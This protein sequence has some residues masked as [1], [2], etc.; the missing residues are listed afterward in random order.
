MKWLAQDGRTSMVHVNK[1]GLSHHALN[2]PSSK[3]FGEVGGRIERCLGELL[4]GDA[5]K[6]CAHDGSSG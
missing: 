3:L 6:S 2:V 1:G 5:L 4:S